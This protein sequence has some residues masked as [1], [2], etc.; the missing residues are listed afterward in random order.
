MG[1]RDANIWRYSFFKGIGSLFS[2]PKRVVKCALVSETG[3]VSLERLVLATGYC[4]WDLQDYKG[5]WVVIQKLMMPMEGS[6]ELVLPISERTYVPLDPLG[7]LDE[8]DRKKLV[9]LDDIA[10]TKYQEAFTRVT[11][12][13]KKN[14]NH[15]LLTT[16]LWGSLVL[17]AIILIVVLIKAH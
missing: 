4:L 16:V 3:I 10:E 2:S 8:E 13:N 6:D 12:E 9:P 17:T 1:F 15:R 14:A 11:E 7:K 5:A